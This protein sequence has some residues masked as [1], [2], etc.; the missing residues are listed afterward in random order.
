MRVDKIGVCGAGKMGSSI[1]LSLAI[2]GYSVLL[3]DVTEDALEKARQSIDTQLAKM[4]GKN[5]ISPEEGK[6]ALARIRMSTE[7]C[8]FEGVDFVIEA[9]AESLDLKKRIFSEL[10]T[11]CRPDAVLVSNTSTFSI[12]AIAYATERPERVAGMHFFLPP[13]RI[14]E[15]T[16][17][18]YTSEASAATVNE[19]G[20][21][22]VRTCINVKKDSPGFIANR[23]YTPLML[24]AF[25]VY[26]EGL[27]SKEEIDRAM[28]G[29]YLPVGP[30][31]LAD[32]IGLDVI[33]SSLEYYESTLGPQW[34]PPVSLRELVNTGCL[35][36]KRGKGWYDYSERS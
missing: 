4:A 23:I 2:A 20:E 3:E 6:A 29:T 31:E 1:A 13:S 5:K 11:V 26:E 27:A 21:K 32:I 10:D 18:R 17:G 33:L 22:L 7:I 15:I 34:N 8:E 35:G 19:V 28:T 9:A 14:V 16:R 25:R 12:T 30:F 36:K 24:E